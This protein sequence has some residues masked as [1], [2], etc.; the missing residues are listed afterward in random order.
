MALLF[1][2][3]IFGHVAIV[4]ISS[5][6]QFMGVFFTKVIFYPELRLLVL[7]ISYTADCFELLWTTVNKSVWTIVNE[8]KQS[9]VTDL[10]N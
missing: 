5:E 4:I 9:R 8:R 10:E 2:R 6:D 1:E 7:P 3:N